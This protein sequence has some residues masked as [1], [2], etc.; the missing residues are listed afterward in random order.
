[1]TGANGK[2]KEWLIDLKSGNGTVIKNPGSYNIA[3]SKNSVL[4][5][6]EILSCLLDVPLIDKKGD[7]TISMSDSDFMDMVTGKLGGQKVL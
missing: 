1:M 2:T 3:M 6:L 4:V 7:C 5:K